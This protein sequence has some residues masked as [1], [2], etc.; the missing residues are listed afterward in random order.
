MERFRLETES[1]G[2]GAVHPRHVAIHYHGVSA[3]EILRERDERVGRN[4]DRVTSRDEPRRAFPGRG[5]DT[6]FHGPVRVQEPAMEKLSP[7]PQ[8]DSALGFLNLR[9]EF[10]PSVT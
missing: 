9:L 8:C 6:L 7:Q 1:V 4:G 2:I 3:A 10:R 5:D